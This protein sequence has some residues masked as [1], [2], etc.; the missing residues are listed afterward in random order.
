MIAKQTIIKKRERALGGA[1]RKGTALASGE[2]TDFVVGGSPLVENNVTGPED[3][4]TDSLPYWRE[5]RV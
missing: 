5:P 2:V 4:T 1:Q 3:N